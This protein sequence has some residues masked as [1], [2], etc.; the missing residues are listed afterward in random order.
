MCV[1]RF[2]CFL[3]MTESCGP[4]SRGGPIPMIPP[5]QARPEL[6][7]SAMGRGIVSFRT[8]ILFGL[9]DG[10]RSVLSHE[11]RGSICEFARRLRALL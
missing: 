10:G 1:E 9:L 5:R 6:F 8:S 2:Q 4:V 11:V 3:D 7:A